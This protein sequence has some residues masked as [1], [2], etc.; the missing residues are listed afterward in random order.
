MID[1]VLFFRFVKGRCHGKQIILG[2]SNERRLIP[3]A[4]FALAFQVEL[5]YHYLDVHINN[6]DDGATSGKNLV[7]F[8]P[9]SPEM[10]ELICV[11][12]YVYLAKIDI[13]TYTSSFVELPFRNA[14][15]YWN[16]DGRVNSGNDQATHA[17]NLLVF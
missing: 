17:I 8:C 14:M 11:P 13:H 15:E 4:F 10:T 6:G 3:P 2:E 1:L 5:Q 12:I 7:N 9:V 16:A